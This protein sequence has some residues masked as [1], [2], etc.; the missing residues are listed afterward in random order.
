MNNIRVELT[1]FRWDKSTYEKLGFLSL[2]GNGIGP[3]V[4]MVNRNAGC[5]VIATLLDLGKHGFTFYGIAE[6][7]WF[8]VA[9]DG[10]RS[11]VAQALVTSHYPVIEIKENGALLGIDQAQ[12]Y[13]DVLAVAQRRMRAAEE[14]H[15]RG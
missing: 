8:L 11:V 2:D 6:E 10:D 12:R 15:L 4:H 7:P 3:V 9:A 14:N 1:C 5:F 13:Y